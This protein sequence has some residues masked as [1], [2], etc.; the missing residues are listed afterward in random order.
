VK[1]KQNKY[2]QRDLIR[3]ILTSEDGRKALPLVKGSYFLNL[4][5]HILYEG[6]QKFYKRTGKIPSIAFL[7]EEVK[8]ILQGQDFT[9]AFTFEEV[10]SLLQ[11]I[12]QYYEGDVD[13]RD[14]V[15]KE[16]AKFASYVEL[17]DVLENADLDDYSSYD[18]FARKI[19]T[20]ISIPNKL[21]DSGGTYIVKDIKE[22]QFKRQSVKTVIPT[23]F[24]QINRLTNAGGYTSGS[25]I[26][27]MDKA[28]HLKTFSLVNWARGYMAA[29]HKVLFIDLEN[30]EDEIAARLDQSMGNLNKKELLRGKRDKEL[31]KIARRYRRLGAEIYV[32]KL[33]GYATANQ[34]QEIIDEQYLSRGIKFD[35]IIIDYIALMG[36]V[37]GKRDDFGRISDAFLDVA[38]L[39]FKNKIKHIV[40]A[41]HVQREA[42]V[43]SGTKY[44]SRDVAKSIDILRH[45]HVI[46]GLQMNSEE[47]AANILRYEVIAQRDGV[48]NGKALMH[49]NVPNQRWKEFTKKEI[50]EYDTIMK[51]SREELKTPSYGDV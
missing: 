35:D 16:V 9:S 23:P 13:N 27:I 4:E 6:I 3:F 12:P 21:E 14:E 32:K 1:F 51:N 28:K 38:N 15:L 11:S 47:E 8:N 25:L 39:G 49:I 18:S 42:E 26:V 7:I 30:G 10:K 20:A 36:A 40:T 43:R 44:K 17:Q 19:G 37:S 46:F 24:W 22:R 48:P 50:T 29:K 45:A 41:M 33:P 34:I 5:H 2:F 31:Q